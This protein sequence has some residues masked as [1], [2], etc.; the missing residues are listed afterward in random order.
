MLQA[1]ITVVVGCE[2]VLGKRFGITC[3]GTGTQGGGL[4]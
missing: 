2:L 3:T 1:I 4:A